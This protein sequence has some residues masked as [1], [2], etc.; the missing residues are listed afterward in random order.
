[1]DLDVEAIKVKIEKLKSEHRGLDQDILRLE[2][3]PSGNP[4][5]MQRLKRRKLALR[6]QITRLESNL[7]PDIIA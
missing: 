3:K 1:M 6:D 5:D 4:L 2:E 7:L